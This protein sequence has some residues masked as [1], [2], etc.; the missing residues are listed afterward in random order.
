MLELSDR[1]R[2]EETEL[3]QKTA[4]YGRV[5]EIWIDEVFTKPSMTKPYWYGT[6]VY[7]TLIVQNY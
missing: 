5:C 6:F 7:E 3:V 1:S 2:T 4:K